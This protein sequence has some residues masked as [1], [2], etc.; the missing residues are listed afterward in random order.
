MQMDPVPAPPLEPSPPEPGRQGVCLKLGNVGMPQLRGVILTF[1]DGGNLGEVTVHGGPGRAART[2]PW[3]LEA[4]A[5]A[6]NVP[7]I[8]MLCEFQV[9]EG[10]GFAPDRVADGSLRIAGKR[11]KWAEKKEQHERKKLLRRKAWEAGMSRRDFGARQPARQ[12]L[13]PDSLEHT[14]VGSG[15]NFVSLMTTPSVPFPASATSSATSSGQPPQMVHQR[16]LRVFDQRDLSED[17]QLAGP[18]DVFA[19]RAPGVPCGWC[20]WHHSPYETCPRCFPR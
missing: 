15:K 18:R 10:G 12:G 13:V 11:D 17:G 14:M 20:F 6:E 2:F 5:P 9:E 4:L 1:P 8:G 16:H 7:G 19:E 3:A